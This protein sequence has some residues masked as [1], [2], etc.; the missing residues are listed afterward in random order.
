ML[1]KAEFDPPDPRV[2]VRQAAG[3]LPEQVLTY[4]RQSS[5]PVAFQR[6]RFGDTTR[7]KITLRCTR[8]S[9][10]IPVLRNKYI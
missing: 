6:L 10:M 7:G 3:Y 5:L 2:L 9:T 1:Q 8:M 4:C